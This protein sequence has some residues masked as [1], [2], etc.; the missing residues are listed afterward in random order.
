[1]LLVDFTAMHTTYQVLFCHQMISCKVLSSFLQNIISSSPSIP[2]CHVASD[3]DDYGFQL[4]SSCI[5]YINSI[6]WYNHRH[7]PD[8]LSSVSLLPKFLPQSQ[9]RTNFFTPVTFSLSMI[10]DCKIGKMLQQELLN[11]LK[12]H[13]LSQPGGESQ[14]QWGHTMNYRPK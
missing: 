1:M 5:N 3:V 13:A 10:Y 7:C 12:K 9:S 2:R 11:T 8:I 4:A 6:L 14:V